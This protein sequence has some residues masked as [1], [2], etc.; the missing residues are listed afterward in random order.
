M[1]RGTLL[2]IVTLATLAYSCAVS[3]ASPLQNASFE[4]GALEPGWSVSGEGIYDGYVIGIGTGPKHAHI[5]A[6]DEYFPDFEN[7]ELGLVFP[8]NVRLTQTFDVPALAQSMFIDIAFLDSSG[9]GDAIVEVRLDRTGFT[10]IYFT[11][12][13]SDELFHTYSADISAAAGQAA[14]IWFEISSP[15]L[16][17]TM[18]A[19]LDVDNIVIT[20]VPEPATL[21]LLAAGGL[22]VLRRRRK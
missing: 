19:T 21:S 9:L 13:P 5:E 20:E 2:C 14:T 16:G 10:S 17:E 7:P 11:V 6:W 15:M 3:S 22:A 1:Y 4:S 8:S 18:Y 12:N